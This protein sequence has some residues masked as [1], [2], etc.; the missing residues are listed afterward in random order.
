MDY[1][2]HLDGETP[3]KK[4][5]R[6][7]LKNGRNIPSQKYR[8]WQ[9]FSSILIVTQTRKLGLKN[10]IEKPV[11][12]HI[13]F[14]HGTLQ[15]RDCDNAASSILDILQDAGVLADDNWQIV[16]EL[17]ISNAYQKGQPSCTITIT[18]IDC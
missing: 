10:P 8:E 5:S 7:C 14:I 12:V 11:S 18:E 4:N 3:P 13:D 16:R 9:Q 15:R 17:H 1:I 2:L 6:I